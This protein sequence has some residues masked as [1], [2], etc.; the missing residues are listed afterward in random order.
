MKKIFI[1]I[2]L[3]I[4]SIILSSCEEEPNLVID[5]IAPIIRMNSDYKTMKINKDTEI[6]N[7]ETFLLQGVIAMD[8]IDGVITENIIVDYSELDIEETGEYTI[9]FH[10]FDKA[11][12]KSDTVTKT[13][14]VNGGFTSNVLAPYKIFTDLIANEKPKPG[15]QSLFKGAW[16]HKVVSSS[17]SWV[18]IEGT[19]TLPSVKIR[20]YNAPFDETLDV[21]PLV[22]NLDN[23]SIYMGGTSKHESDVG[24]SY[25]LVYLDRN[26]TVLST[27]SYAFRP[28]WRYITS[29]NDPDKDIGIANPAE[30]RFY[31][32]TALNANQ[33]NMYANWYGSDTQFYYLPGDKL[34]IVVY[35][36]VPNFV[37]LQIEVIEQSTIPS[38]IE[39]RKENKWRDPADFFSPLIKSEGHGANLNTVYKRVNAIDQSANEGKDVIPTNSEV[40]HAVW[41]SVYLHRKIDGIMYRVPFN[42]NRSSTLNAPYNSAFTVTEINDLTGGTSVTIH[43][44]KKD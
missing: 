22:K 16:Y 34:R 44:G 11:G 15:P 39:I 2:V 43:P 32:V 23:P 30:G 28:F 17:D 19:I 3:T 13:V 20:R 41:E 7:L 35:S 10:V 31:S 24:L 21:D 1:L 27:G 12:N 25:S 33:T 37:Q 14:L 40:S 18:G 9:Y 6:V 38:S 26:G 8:N 4:S 29:V 42:E 5:E 36:P